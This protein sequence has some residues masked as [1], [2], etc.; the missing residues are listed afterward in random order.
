M[1]CTVL[2]VHTLHTSIQA[3]H[4]FFYTN[5]IGN[6][7]KSGYQIHSAKG[8]KIPYSQMKEGNIILYDT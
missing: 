3:L 6:K 7:L 1:Y 8:F 4:F 2:M 5:S